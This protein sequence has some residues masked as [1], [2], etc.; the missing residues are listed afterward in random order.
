M[1]DIAYMVI[2]E[3]SPGEIFAMAFAVVLFAA[4]PAAMLLLFGAYSD[5]MRWLIGLGLVTALGIVALYVMR[6]GLAKEP[7]RATGPGPRTEYTGQLSQLTDAFERAG[8]G[9]AY[10][11]HLIR[12]RLCEIIVAR[13][14]QSRDMGEEQIWDMVEAGRK[15]VIGDALLD[16][17]LTE[18]RR[19]AGGTGA[20]ISKGRSRERGERFMAEVDLII[21]RVEAMT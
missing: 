20:T 15:G 7:V 2:G 14:A 11:Q 1:G 9:Y 8:E 21:E 13:E 10:S 4:T 5:G 18:N 17:F 19:G 6:M 12:E 3:A 16:R